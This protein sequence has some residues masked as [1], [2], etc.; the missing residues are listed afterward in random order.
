GIPPTTGHGALSGWGQNRGD[1]SRPALCKKLALEMES[2][3][4]SRQPDMG[5]QSEHSAAAQAE[6]NTSARC[7]AYAHLEPDVGAAGETGKSRSDPPGMHT[8]R[9]RADSLTAYDLS[10]HPAS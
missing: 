9:D 3:L 5:H 6:P 7:R 4:P 8:A 1:L 10:Y 2:T